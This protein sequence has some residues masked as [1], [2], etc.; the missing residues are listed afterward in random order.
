MSC[1]VCGSSSLR[2]EVGYLRCV[3]CR[4]MSLLRQAQTYIVNDPPELKLFEKMDIR[5]RFQVGTVSSFFDSDKVLVDIGCGPGRFLNFVR[6]G[7]RNVFGLEVTKECLDFARSELSLKLFENFRDLRVAMG[8]G[9]VDIF[10]AWHSLEHIPSESLSEILT[11]TSEA[12]DSSTRFIVCVPNSLSYQFLFF[13]RKWLYFDRPNHLH[14]FSP[15]SL[16]LL[17]AKDGWEPEREVF[18]FAYNFFGNCLSFGNIFSTRTNFLYQFLKRKNVDGLNQWVLI[19]ELVF[20][21]L[22]LCIGLIPSIIL[23]LVERLNM[24]RAGVMTVCFK[25][26]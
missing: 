6:K 18:S 1:V 14:Q 13:G 11:L 7:F 26:R 4:H 2:E 20:A 16:C 5:D 19:K 12:S 9:K 3:D 10:T 17:F 22:G 15:R 8:N 25:K 21:S 24:N 23:T